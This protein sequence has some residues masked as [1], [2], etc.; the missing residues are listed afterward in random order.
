M[1]DLLILVHVY[2]AVHPTSLASE[3]PLLEWGTG[4]VRFP[5]KFNF[6]STDLLSVFVIS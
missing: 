3:S 1:C 2:H 6:Y 4:D 5:R